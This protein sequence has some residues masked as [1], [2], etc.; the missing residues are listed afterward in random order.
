MPNHWNLTSSRD[1]TTPTCEDLPVD[2]DQCY[3]TSIEYGVHYD[4]A[5]NFPFVDIMTF[6]PM[7]DKTQS[8]VQSARVTEVRLMY[9]RPEVWEKSCHAR[10][11][12]EVLEGMMGGGGGAGDGAGNLFV[13]NWAAVVVPFAVMFALNM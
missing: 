1:I 8:R 7:V 10:T 2:L 12:R 11:A 9:L 3:G 4:V 6:F 13:G 5:L